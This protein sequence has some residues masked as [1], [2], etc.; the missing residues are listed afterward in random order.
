[1][2]KNDLLFSL[3]L[4]ILFRVVFMTIVGTT[5][6]NFSVQGAPQEPQRV[7]MNLKN[8]SPSVVF[9]EI[10]KQTHYKF[11]YNDVQ[12]KNLDKVTINV[13]NEPVKS[14]LDTIFKDTRYTY[15]ISGE[16]I[17]VIDRKEEKTPIKTEVVI[18][19]K[20][21]GKDSSPIVGASIVLKGTYSGVAT[22][23]NGTFKMRMP[24]IEGEEIALEVSFVG[25]KKQEVHVQGLPNPAPLIV[26]LEE[27]VVG[28][29][30]VVVNGYANIKKSSF[31]GTSTQVKREDILKVS[32]QN[33]I[34]VLQ[35]FEPS[36]R[37]VDNNEMGSDP[38][39]LPE[40]YIRGQT[41]IDGVKQLDQVESSGS[42]N[43]S[44]F[45]LT[46]NPNLPI[47]ILDGYEVGVEK[48][49]D[50]DPNR[51][52]SITILKDAAATAIYG[53]RAANGIIMIE[54]VI[55]ELGKLNI[56]YSMNM[57][58]TAPDLSGYDLMNAE[59]KLEAE[60]LAGI[61]DLSI[62]NDVTSYANKRNNVMKGIDTDW[63]S[64]PLQNQWNNSH[65]LFIDG[66]TK[67]FR[68][69]ASLSTNYNGGVMK[70]SH[71]QTSSFGMYVD[72]SVGKLKIRNHVTYDIANSQDSPYGSFADYT[73]QQPYEEFR[74]ENGKYLQTLPLSWRANPLYEASLG[75]FSRSNYNTITNNLSF[76]WYISKNLQFKNQFSVTKQY[77]ESKDFKDPNSADYAYIFDPFMRGELSISELTTSGWN[78]N[79]F[80]AYNA[81]IKKSNINISSG[82]NASANNTSML[83]SNYRGFPSPELNSV[84]HAREIVNK[85]YGLDNKTRL[86]GLFLS[87][88]YTYDNIY[89]ADVSLRFDG[90][91]EFGT[92]R[93][94]APFW[95]LGFGINIHNYEFM[96]SY[97]FINQLKIRATYGQTG[98]V[99]YPP[100]AARDTYTV[101]LD[102]WYTTGIGAAIYNFGNSDLQ[103]EKTNNIN[104]GADV[105]LFNGKVYFSGSWYNRQ[106]IDMITDV[107]IPS[108]SGFTTYKSNMG[109]VRNRGYEMTLNYR[110]IS[111]K[112]FD[113]SSFASLSHNKGTLVK[114]GESLEEYNERVN[115]FMTPINQWYA[116]TEAQAR[117]FLKY[118]E[119]GSLTA[120]Y[121][122]KSMG[123]NPMDGKEVFVNRN[124]ELTSEWDATQQQIIGNSEP[125]ARGAFGFNLRYKRFTLYSTFMYE[126][127]GQIYNQTLVNKVEN[128]DLANYNADKRVLLQRW[129]Q[130]GDITPLKDIADRRLMTQPTSR[131]VQDKNEL[132]FN[133]I[134]L[135]Y[136]FKPE[137]V[138]KIG[139]N[140]LR[141]QASANDIVTI[142]TIKQERGMSY[143]YARTFNFNLS[144]SF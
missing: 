109:E 58:L 42:G 30:E 32:H 70:G 108:S 56:S 115:E 119:G 22:D 141:L 72:Y 76:D 133:S 106:T 77:S 111:T 137:L 88:N 144:T 52:A 57:S 21:I 136:D 118:E 51:I 91:S 125:K 75:S 36:L 4:K 86:A 79:S 46:N 15:K 117:P 50:M 97:D 6:L 53:S 138:K 38:N 48:V 18:D 25:M 7:T 132:K 64:Q 40:F 78:L 129:Q 99:N 126:F 74:N 83:N 139:L 41:S 8:V 107:T 124:G 11:F 27:N 9:K 104:I 34:E 123:I 93:R 63:K 96:K 2:K 103:W 31:T 1:M 54:S 102:D 55:P 127:G 121:G 16:Q 90:S 140:T 92:D 23:R 112:D 73:K 113:L 89:L 13:T 37:L 114:L 44:R 17:I 94:V 69:G 100:Y 33:V 26:V 10:Q 66:G 143:P 43:L 87:A 116:V 5:F 29:D 45:A 47:F 14:V 49:Y 105:S 82:L 98:K 20:V 39:T 24:W 80:I 3:S 19:G 68:F 122:M 60:L 130:P 62:P 85:P 65:S 95:S 131:F 128:V 110:V 81:T 67:G 28:V 59:E 71:R 84:G 35:V 101:L 61:Y 142:S 135:G 120:I 134:S 12:E